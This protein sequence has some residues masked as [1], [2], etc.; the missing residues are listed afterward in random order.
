VLNERPSEEERSAVVKPA[1]VRL[2]SFATIHTTKGD[3]SFELFPDLCPKTVE[4]FVVHSRNKY[5]NSLT[6]HRVVKG[7]V[8]QT[9][10]PMGDGTGGNSIWGREFED[11]F[12]HDLRHDRPGVLSMANAGKNS[13]GSQFFITVTALPRLDNKHTVFGRIIKGM[14]V[15]HDIE[16]SRVD[17]LDKPIEDVKIINIDIQ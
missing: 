7:F 5:Y 8:I 4:N 12:H 13:N 16:K 1:K 2:G 15:V 14:E 6:F 9:G 3:M 10:D 11:E 17:K